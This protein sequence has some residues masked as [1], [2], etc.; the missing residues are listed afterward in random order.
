MSNAHISAL[1]FNG[2]KAAAK[3]RIQ[4]L[5]RARLIS[6]RPRHP[7]EPSIIFITKGGL[8]ELALRGILQEYP[9]INRSM[10]ENRANVS[11][12]TLRHELDVLDVKAQLWSA[13]SKSNLFTVTEFTTWPRLV[14]FA[15]GGTVVKPDAFV[16]IRHPANAE[17]FSEHS[18]FVE[19]DRSTEALNLLVRRAACYLAYYKSG[20][21]AERSGAMRTAVRDYPLRVLFILKTEERRNNITERLLGHS[22]P[23]LSHVWL[24]T[25][26]DLKRDPLGAIWIRPID[27]RNATAGTPYSTHRSAS[28]PEYRRQTARELHVAKALTK[29]P[30]I[31]AT[32]TTAI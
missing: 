32:V 14:Q 8:A 31:A 10:L 17:T 23:I 21:F 28:T 15:V 16:R 3:K 22:P 19:L 26:S 29:H 2:H 5:K 24:T 12:L 18:F 7:F 30:L 4:T 20:G 11:L 27:Y 9:G 25:L 13:S 1:H 6:E